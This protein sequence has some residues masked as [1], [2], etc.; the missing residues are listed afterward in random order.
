M[1]VIIIIAKTSHNCVHKTHA[2]K[3]VKERIPP[4]LKIKAKTNIRQAEKVA[5]GKTTIN[6]KSDN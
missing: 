1:L 5:D 3:R 2:E 4:K 6:S